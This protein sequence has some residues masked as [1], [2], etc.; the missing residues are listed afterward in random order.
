KDI[1]DIGK[2][3]GSETITK[4]KENGYR[5]EPTE[6]GGLMLV[7]KDGQLV[8]SSNVPNIEEAKNY[9]EQKWINDKGLGAQSATW[10]GLDKQT[11]SNSINAGLGLQK[12][13]KS[14]D[15]IGEKYQY[16]APSKGDLD[17]NE[18]DIVPNGEYAE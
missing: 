17:Y 7:T 12:E 10:Q 15:T 18:G 11:I 8:E 2:V 3:M 1:I 4:M 9:L 16:V 5:F 6:Q 14:L 13:T